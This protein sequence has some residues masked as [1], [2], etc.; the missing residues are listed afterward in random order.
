MAWTAQSIMAFWAS[1]DP[2]P[3]YLKKYAAS[4]AEIVNLF[5]ADGAID[6]TSVGISLGNCNEGDDPVW[7]AQNFCTELQ[8][9]TGKPIPA[10]A[11][12]VRLVARA[13]VPLPPMAP[14]QV[15]AEALAALDRLRRVRTPALA[16]RG[17]RVAAQARD[18]LGQWRWVQRGADQVLPYRETQLGR[19]PGAQDI[20]AFTRWV[21][22]R[23]PVPA[24]A[25]ALNCREA[26][27]VVAVQSGVLSHG[28]LRGAHEG[29]LAAAG[30][31]LG[32]VLL[33]MQR[34]PV[35]AWTPSMVTTGEAAAVRYTQRLDDALFGRGER[36]RY[37][38]RHGVIPRAGDIV[39]VDGDAVPAHVC[40]SLG[41]SWVGGQ[42]V[43]QVASLWHHDAGTFSLQGLD[44]IA[45]HWDLSFLPCPL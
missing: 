43:D 22:G 9:N 3:D 17:A 44:N 40:V 28:L 35:T 13:V 39:F 27:L 41:R 7:I 14:E 19:S 23:A 37:R 38:P 21:Q 32:S 8:D 24:G 42:P 29:A 6:H 15:P 12:A 26:V 16:G 36:F 10:A 4:L 34:A 5:E 45:P 18:L 1:S 31:M 33:Q 30:A 2:P 20:H 11:S 25:T